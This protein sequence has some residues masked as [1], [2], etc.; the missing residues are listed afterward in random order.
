MFSSDITQAFTNSGLDVSLFCYPPAGYSCQ[1]GKVLQVEL[2]KCLYSAKQAP[3]RFKAVLTAFMIAEGY[4]AVN[5]AQTVWIKT[6]RNLVL[7]NAIFVDDVHHCTNDL[8]MYRAFRKKFEK[9]FDLKA[10]NHIDVY[11][12]NQIIHDRK[13]GTVTVSKQHYVMACLEKF[14]LTHCH[15]TDTPMTV[16]LS[17]TDQPSTI[18][19]KNQEQ[20]RGMVG[21]L[22]GSTWHHGLGLT[23]RS[24]YRSSLDSCPIPGS[25]LLSQKDNAPGTHVPFINFVSGSTRHAA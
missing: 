11:L 25:R 16:R 8:V 14:G 15:G 18:D 13:K 3:A 4:R 21:S 20:F 1:T 5:D 23:L 24:Q 7:I 19:L 6:K 17:T 10:D 2:N 12:G 9:K 22:Q